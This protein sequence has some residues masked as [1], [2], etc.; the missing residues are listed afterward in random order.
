MTV[1]ASLVCRN[2]ATMFCNLATASGTGRSAPINPA[3]IFE[4]ASPSDAKN[5]RSATASPATSIGGFVPVS[6]P[7]L[8]ATSTRVSTSGPAVGGAKDDPRKSLIRPK[9]RSSR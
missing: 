6:L 7:R 3:L 4:Q 5:S 2:D 9:T 8:A 1:S